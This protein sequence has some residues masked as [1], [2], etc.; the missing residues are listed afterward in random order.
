MVDSRLSAAC[1]GVGVQQ[2]VD[3]GQ[4]KEQQQSRK[5]V[6]AACMHRVVDGAQA[7]VML[8]AACSIA[9]DAQACCKELSH[10]TRLQCSKHVIFPSNSANGSMA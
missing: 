8:S 9:C 6:Q 3:G 5:F 7:E 2:S 10:C 1:I 4:Q